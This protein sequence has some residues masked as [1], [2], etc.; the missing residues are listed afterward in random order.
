MSEFSTEEDHFLHASQVC[1]VGFCG[2]ISR[3]ALARCHDGLEDVCQFFKWTHLQ[4]RHQNQRQRGTHLEKNPHFHSRERVLGREVQGWSGARGSRVGG[5]KASTL[6]NKTTT[7]PTDRPTDEATNQTRRHTHQ[8]PNH[9]THPT[10][11]TTQSKLFECVTK[12]FFRV[13]A[14]KVF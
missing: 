8:P 6:I 7:Q 14:K 1:L 3:R 5:S 11:P 9:T 10:H 12:M 4:G 2:N 13:D